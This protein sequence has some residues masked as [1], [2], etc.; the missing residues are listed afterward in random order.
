M[1]KNFVSTNFQKFL[2]P[3]RQL[4]RCI[5][6]IIF[7]VLDIDKPNLNSS[8]SDLLILASQN[9]TLNETSKFSVRCA[10]TSSPGAQYVWTTS[11]KVV[12]NS[13]VLSFDSIN[14]R[15]ASVYQCTVSNPAGAKVAPSLTIIVQC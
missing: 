15:N 11:G 1:V 8:T 3:G 9:I 10:L 6:Q 14:R 7:P 2:N 4:K 5:Q 13:A 12:S